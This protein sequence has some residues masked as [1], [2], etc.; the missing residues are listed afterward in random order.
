MKSPVF[1]LGHGSP[2]NAVTENSWTQAVRRAGEGF[3]KPEALIVVS[4]H[5]LTEG[6]Q[7]HASL[8]PKTIHDFR[9]FP[10]ELYR[11]RYPA[12]GSEKWAREVQRLL[13]RSEVT[14]DWGFDHGVWGVLS[15]LRPL[16]DVPV[17]PISLNVR[18][19]SEDFFRMGENLR[20]LRDQNVWII[21]SGNLVH[22]LREIDF[23]N[24]ETRAPWAE[25]FDRNVENFVKNGDQTRLLSWP[26]KD[27]KTFL[28]A[29]PTSEHWAPF[30][31]ALGAAG[32]IQAVRWIHREI[33]NGSISMRSGVWS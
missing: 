7:I 14:D 5:W 12:P 29:H 32:D 6:V 4:A 8:Q 31:V 1:F 33:Q 11:L 21:A 3:E 26:E 27:P 30:L 20:P 10:D 2:M 16:A 28:R 15:F 22:N 18:F 13:P 17:V 25:E 9:G 19:R 23:K 24:V